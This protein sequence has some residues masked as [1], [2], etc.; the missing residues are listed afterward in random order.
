[1]RNDLIFQQ[2]RQH[3]LQVIHGALYESQQWREAL[4]LAKQSTQSDR[5]TIPKTKTIQEV[6][7]CSASMYCL[8]DASW[9]NEKEVG[10]IGWSLYN[11]E[12]IHKLY[13]PLQS[14]PQTLH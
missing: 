14:C 6:L 13:A 11:K 8:V 3:I 1:M 7:P 5:K 10:G 2:N 12:G 9:V 4:Q